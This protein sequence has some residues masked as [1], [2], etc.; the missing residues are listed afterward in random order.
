[1]SDLEHF[2]HMSNREHI[3]VGCGGEGVGP[4]R[5]LETDYMISGH[6]NHF[7]VLLL[8]WQIFISFG[9]R[10]NGCL[11]TPPRY[12]IYWNQYTPRNNTI[13]YSL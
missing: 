9:L 1:M 11:I 5:G 6:I 12:N 2:L 8:F 13:D 4:I 10:C 3:L 7:F